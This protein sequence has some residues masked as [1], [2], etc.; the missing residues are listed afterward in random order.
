MFNPYS[1]VIKSQQLAIINTRLEINL[2]TT[3][4]YSITLSAKFPSNG[5][6]CTLYDDN[7]SLIPILV[8][9]SISKGSS[10]VILSINP[11]SN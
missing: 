3:F 5:L 9:Y 11:E 7:S 4:I 8:S 1:V 2:W 6:I 10:K